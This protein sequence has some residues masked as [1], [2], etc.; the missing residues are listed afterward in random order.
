MPSR[1]A[2]VRKRMILPPKC[3]Y[4]LAET[5]FSW[6]GCLRSLT[7][8]SYRGQAGPTFERADKSGRLRVPQKERYFSQAV[9]TVFKVAQRETPARVIHDLSEVSCV[10]LHLPLQGAPAHGHFLCD[11][12]EI[13]VAISHGL[14]NG[15]S[16]RGKHAG[17]LRHLVDDPLEISLHDLVKPLVRSGHLAFEEFTFDNKIIGL[18]T[19]PNGRA[20]DSLVL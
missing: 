12:R 15:F 14:R 7:A 20:K 6:V 3:D 8:V 17:V 18:I 9:P 2:S 11:T 10:F 13:G 19:K 5:D 4:E 16:Y 1:S